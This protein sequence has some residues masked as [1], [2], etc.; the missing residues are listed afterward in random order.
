MQH[1]GL[2][3]KGSILATNPTCLTPNM[4]FVSGEGELFLGNFGAHSFPARY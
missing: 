2:N 4:F 3:F 1:F